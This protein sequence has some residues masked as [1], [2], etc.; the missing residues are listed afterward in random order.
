MSEGAARG[1]SEKTIAAQ[2]QEIERLRDALSLVA[3]A[4]IIG[5][6]VTHAR[7]LEMIVE[8]GAH[9]IG[10]HAG[11]LFLLD[12]DEDELTFEVAIGSRAAEVK[13]FRVPLGHGIAGIVAASGQAM[14]I[15]DAANDPRL[16]SDIADSVGYVPRTVLCVPLFYGDSVIGALELLDK[17]G[18]QP[19]TGSDL[20]AL[21]LFAN[22]AAV[23]LQLS[24]T[25]QNVARLLGEGVET[26]AAE[27]T[28][29]DASREALELAN[30]VH[31]IARQG[32]GERKACREILLGFAEYLRARSRVA[33]QLTSP[34]E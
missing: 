23:A 21:G 13:R 22:Q 19:F 16:A 15:S 9:V 31:E 2:A 1:H 7:L 33:D 29:D 3:T 5:S 17:E 18:G 14:A 34:V 24:R 26:G 11:A 25:Y 10:A 8:T 6:P 30:L 28:E 20:E 4:G 27:A 12:E 32:E